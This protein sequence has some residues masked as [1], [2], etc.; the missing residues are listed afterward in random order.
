VLLL[1]VTAIAEF[2]QHRLHIAFE[3]VNRFSLGYVDRPGQ[4]T[5]ETA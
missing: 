1:V 2:R 5:D 4:E 3:N